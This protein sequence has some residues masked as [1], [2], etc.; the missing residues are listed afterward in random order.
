MRRATTGL[1]A[2]LAIAL[3]GAIVALAADRAGGARHE[4]GL[5]SLG[6]KAYFGILTEEQKVAAKEIVADHLA[7]TQADRLAA[8]A[9]FLEYRANVA[10]VLT[11]IR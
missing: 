8:A 10:A 4:R 11:P 3:A 7:A 5:R 2:V 6:L 1:A 9:R